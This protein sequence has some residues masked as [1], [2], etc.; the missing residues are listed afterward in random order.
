MQFT[1]LNEIK[2]TACIDDQV[3][4][5]QKSIVRSG[6]GQEVGSVRGGR[7]VDNSAARVDNLSTW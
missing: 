3:K 2:P 6:F 7:T 4:W 5:D 1:L